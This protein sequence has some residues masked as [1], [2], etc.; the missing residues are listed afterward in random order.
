MK[1]GAAAAR[2]GSMAGQPLPAAVRH[3]LRSPAAY[4]GPCVAPPEGG[5]VETRMSWVFLAGAHV[6]KL[7]KA[8]HDDFVDFSTLTACKACCREE[9]R[10]NTRRTPCVSLGPE[11]CAGL[12]RRRASEEAVR[13]EADDIARAG[14]AHRRGGAHQAGARRRFSSRWPGCRW[15]G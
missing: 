10:L 8:V 6:L 1:A 7:K 11:R 3:F 4:A 13:G 5:T 2:P 12:A 15:R 14:L 9:P